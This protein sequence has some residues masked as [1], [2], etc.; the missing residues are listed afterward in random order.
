MDTR[1]IPKDKALKCNILKKEY[2]IISNIIIQIQKVI[3][4]N[5][6]ILNYSK[7]NGYFACN[8]SSS[9]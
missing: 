3:I 1:I 5:E 2:M 4:D 7:N 8:F 6:I 9:A